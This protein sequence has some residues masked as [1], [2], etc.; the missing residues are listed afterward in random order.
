MGHR[1]SRST[2]TGQEAPRRLSVTGRFVLSPSSR[3]LR[4]QRL[5]PWGWGGGCS[6][7]VKRTRQTKRLGAFV[8]RE[9][10][11]P[12]AFVSRTLLGVV[13]PGP[14][15]AWEAGEG[16]GFLSADSAGR[17]PG[18]HSVS[19]GRGAAYP[20]RRCTWTPRGRRS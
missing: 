10:P 4:S 6:V 17:A 20:E 15:G 11:L 1:F 9:P 8:P 16:L 2:L 5:V 19:R 13:V 3:S 18:P 7:G 12:G 14:G